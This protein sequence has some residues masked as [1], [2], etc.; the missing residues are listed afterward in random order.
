MLSASSAL[1]T[2]DFNLY[3]QLIDEANKI[4]DAIKKDEELTYECKNFGISN[5]IFENALPKIFKSNKI[6][7][8]LWE[9]CICLEI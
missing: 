8:K 3:Y 6:I 9:V 5:Y 7:F 2:K 4:V 1:E